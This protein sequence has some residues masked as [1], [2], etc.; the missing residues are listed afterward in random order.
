MHNSFRSP[1]LP[2]YLDVGYSA[3]VRSCLLGSLAAAEMKGLSGPK[4]L[5]VHPSSNKPM[6][7]VGLPGVL[8]LRCR[9]WVVLFLA[10]FAYVH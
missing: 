2:N 4:L 3:P 6:R 1:S 8:G 7:G 10:G 5:A 9:L